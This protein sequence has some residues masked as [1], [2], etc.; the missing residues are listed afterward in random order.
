[1][2]LTSSLFI[3]SIDLVILS[4]IGAITLNILIAVNHKPGRYQA[5]LESK[6][7]KITDSTLEEELLDILI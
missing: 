4:V 7:S 5:Y 2:I 1:V 3:F 6:T